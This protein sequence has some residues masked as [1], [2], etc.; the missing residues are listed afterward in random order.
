VTCVYRILKVGALCLALASLPLAASA[1]S[2]RKSSDP[3][4]PALSMNPD[5]G[6]AEKLFKSEMQRYN[7][8]STEN[9]ARMQALD[10]AAKASYKQ[11][12][13]CA[14]ACTDKLY[15]D[16]ASGKMSYLNFATKVKQNYCNV[17]CGV[18]N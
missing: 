15:A 13:A 12:L 17:T 9:A 8:T 1:D 2:T 16:W 4:A 14:K 10:A 7:E 3:A 5:A 18:Q 11:K 6:N